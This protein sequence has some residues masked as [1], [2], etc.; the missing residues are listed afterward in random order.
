[1][2]IASDDGAL[3]CWGRNE[4]GQV[5][6]GTTVERKLV[7]GQA[8]SGPAVDCGGAHAVEVGLGT[9]GGCAWL[10][11]GTLKCWGGNGGGELGLG[12]ALA[13]GATP[14]SQVVASKNLYMRLKLQLGPLWI[15]C[16]QTDERVLQ[17]NGERA[18][19]KAPGRGA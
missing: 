19:Q 2:C 8:L 18:R 3:R 5:R 4:T 17:L 14:R 9:Y 10:D 1:M 13:R 7:P 11:N 16:R 15:R 6:Q 12:D